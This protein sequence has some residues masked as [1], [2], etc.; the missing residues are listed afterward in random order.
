MRE[1]A[2]QARE[3]Q[4]YVA[5]WGLAH[6]RLCVF[7]F[8]AEALERVGTIANARIANARML[9]LFHLIISLVE[10]SHIY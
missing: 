2:A 3:S 6:A 5:R 8:L 7:R 1:A 9:R 4:N 10:T